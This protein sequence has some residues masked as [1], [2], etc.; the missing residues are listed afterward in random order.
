MLIINVQRVCWIFSVA[1]LATGVLWAEQGILVLH[2][3]DPQG[4]PLAGVQLATEGDGSTSPLTDRAGKTRLRLAAQTPEGAWLTLMVVRAPRDLVFV[5]PW[6]QR[7]VVPPFT[8]ETDN[9]VPIILAN[10]GDR[11]MLESGAAIMAMAASINQVISPKTPDALSPEEQ[12]RRALEEVSR[13]FGLPESEID[14]AIRA[15][16]QKTDDVYEQGLVALYE[17]NYPEA[18]RRLAASL[19]VR[20]ANFQKARAEAADAAF[21]LGISL[22]EQ[23]RYK[24]C[25]VAHQRALAIRPDD[26]AALSSLGAAFT[27]TAQHDKA[28]P[29]LRRALTITEQA[30]GPDH[31]DTAP[32]LNNLA[33]VLSAKGDNAEAEPLFRR[34]LAIYEKALGPD[35]PR[36][37][38][39]I[40][41]L[42]VLLSRKGDYA[43]AEPLLRRALAICEKALGSGHPNTATS[44]N[45]LSALLRSK[46]DYAGAEPLFRRALAIRE[47]ALGPDHPHTAISLN[48]LAELLRAKGDYV[49]AEPLS[50]RGLAITE[51]ALGP[52]HPEAANSLNNLAL[53][54]S[55]KGD[56]TGAEPLTRRALAITEKALGPDHPGTA[57]SLNNLAALLRRTGDYEGQSRCFAA[58]WRSTRRRWA[59]S[60][61][62]R[63]QPQQS[64]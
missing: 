19:R 49:G 13:A 55:A 7:V 30:L 11:L 6:N 26:P 42:A 47:K 57:T 60:P 61:R 4:R 8:H 24:E 14:Q 27:A 38:E 29:L 21:F 54:L 31:A 52:D 2:V 43:E 51:K 63:N 56:D 50:R 44:L 37:A 41:N 1:A 36:T 39:S 10:R 62:H 18:S 12:K 35:H 20:E 45:N 53:L 64:G 9:Y 15:W 22:Y 46:G 5:S 58:P 48:N 17:K 33:E 23:G 16:G 3:K 32:S 34:G 28:E 25:T 59:R 40:N